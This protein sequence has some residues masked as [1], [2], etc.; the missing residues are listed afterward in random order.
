LVRLEHTLNITEYFQ[1]PR[2]GELRGTPEK[3]K[4][5]EYTPMDDE[6]KQVLGELI[7]QHLG[8]TMEVNNI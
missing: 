7:Q 1:V 5:S 3:T 6:T 4:I 2:C 8:L